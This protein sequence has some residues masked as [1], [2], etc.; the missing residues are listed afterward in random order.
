MGLKGLRG[1][2]TYAAAGVLDQPY[3]TRT[4]FP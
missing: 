3:G 4:T 1:G 2:R